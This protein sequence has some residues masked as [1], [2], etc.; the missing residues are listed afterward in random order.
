M[1]ILIVSVVSGV[2]LHCSA[3]ITS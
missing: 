1:S 3:T 2:Y